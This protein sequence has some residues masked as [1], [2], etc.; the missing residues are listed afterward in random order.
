MVLKFLTS[1]ANLPSQ[2]S[3]S[4]ARFYY[5]ENLEETT[6]RNMKNPRTSTYTFLIFA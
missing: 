4:T 1:T 2:A 6:E 5:K 3:K